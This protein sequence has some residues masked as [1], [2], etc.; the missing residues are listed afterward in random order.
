MECEVIY[1]LL[2]FRASAALTASA[3]LSAL[4]TVLAMQ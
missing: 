3:V 4:A 2:F 1:F